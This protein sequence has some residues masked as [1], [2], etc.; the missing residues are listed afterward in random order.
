MSRRKTAVMRRPGLT[1]CGAVLCLWGCTALSAYRVSAQEAPNLQ[2]PNLRRSEPGAAGVLRSS[3]RGYPWVNLTDAAQLRTE[4]SEVMELS[5]GA[6]ESLDPLSLAAGDFDQDGVPDLVCGFGTSTGGILTLYRGNVDSVFPDTPEAQRRKAA[7]TFHDGPFLPRPYAVAVPEKPQLLGVGDFNADRYLDIVL[8]GP[9]GG[10]L[11]LL[12]GDGRGSF[13]P[14]QETRLPGQVT[15]LLTG[16]INRRDRLADI[17]LGVSGPEGPRL[18]VFEW[19]HGALRSDPEV[20]PL[21]SEA[22]ALALGQLDE[23]Y[24]ID[25]AVAAGSEVLIMHGRD[26]S[27]TVPTPQDISPRKIESYSFTSS[28][29]S[30]AVGDF[31]G[32]Y[33]PELAVLLE[34]STIELLSRSE[35]GLETRFRPVVA[36]MSLTPLQA[37]SGAAT[38]P[39]LIRA[40][41]S[42]LPKD[43]LLLVDT[44]DSS[45]HVLVLDD[46]KRA[47]AQSSSAPETPW[48]TALRV[49]DQPVAVL[50]MRLNKHALSGLVILRKGTSIPTTME[51]QPERTFTVNQDTDESDANTLDDRCDVDDDDGNGEQCTLRAAIDQANQSVGLDEIVFDEIVFEVAKISPQ[52]PLNPTFF[53]AVTI[54]GTLKEGN[55]V[56]LDG[57]AAGISADGL[58][59][60]GGDS[61]IRNLVIHS[62]QQTGV[63]LS[64]NNNRLEGSF[65]GTNRTGQEIRKN[66]ASGVR[67]GGASTKTIIGGATTASRNIIS[68]NGD[69]FVGGV[70]IE[71]PA[72]VENAILNNLIGVDV[73][74]TRP[75]ENANP[76]VRIEEGATNNVVAHNLI[77]GNVQDGILLDE[78]TGTIIQGNGIGI[79]VDDFPGLPNDASG[80][81]IF[82]STGTTVG[83][84][85]DRP[86]KF[87]FLA[88]MKSPDDPLTPVQPCNVIAGNKSQGNSAGIA[89]SDSSGTN[90]QGN[91]IMHNDGAGVSI[92]QF[93]D[94]S[95]LNTIGGITPGEGN[96]IQ[97][98]IL[99]GIRVS[100]DK[101]VT[102]AILGNS[103]FENGGLGINL[104]VDGVTEN[105]DDDSDPGPNHLQNFPVLTAVSA[106]TI[107]GTLSGAAGRTFRLEFFSN[108]E[109][110]PS[111]HGEGEKFIDSLE[112]GEQDTAQCTTTQDGDLTFE[113]SFGALPGQRITATATELLFDA[114]GNTSEFSKCFQ[115]R[116]FRVNSAG[117]E[118]DEDEKEGREFD[119]VCDTGEPEVNGK[120][121]C[122]LRAAVAEANAA[123]ITDR[124]EFA[125]KDLEIKPTHPLKITTPVIIDGTGQNITIDGSNRPSEEQPF[126]GLIIGGGKSLVKGL[127]IKGFKSGAGI[128]LA[129]RGG[130]KIRGNILTENNF[131]IGIGPGSDGNRIGG[132]LL[133]ESCLDPCN[134]VSGNEIS[135]I[136]ITSSKLNRVQGNFIGTDSTGTRPSGN[137]L[138]VLISSLED[139]PPAEKNMIGGTQPGEGNLIS[140]NARCGI[141]LVGEVDGAVIQGNFIGTSAYKRDNYLPPRPM[142][143]R[144]PTIHCAGQ[145]RDEADIKG[146]ESGW[147]SNWMPKLS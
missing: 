45:I 100:G 13:G 134:W 115:P 104:G 136:E 113:T 42:S 83:G 116:V 138:G 25:L 103:I 106:Q 33:E 46:A 99:D 32:T 66:G 41:I 108:T 129:Q 29:A 48:M 124:I 6:Q 16:E 8:A 114:R 133:E 11:F 23:D 123:S 43:D 75:L 146:G 54:D 143:T 111:G 64:G 57:S 126:D 120:P 117:D 62:F 71:G 140:G 82:D 74:G 95:S 132:V 81:R 49:G 15:A 142:L 63:S 80:I 137:D 68:G 50:P 61:L 24:P 135:G 144:H 121:E 51:P 20:F 127:T 77:S 147:F 91:R 17:V 30:L 26:R 18:L 21:P 1:Y 47:S 53:E 34:D 44:Q 19:S 101:T 73:T 90:V 92:S 86:C 119:G 93:A 94:G 128:V 9:G 67:I 28:I 84:P 139:G 78:A 130:N 40:R 131:G 60:G 79:D 2:E 107:T 70:V 37:P 5:L 12:P 125:I 102:N 122:T 39:R 36:A 35:E 58:S 59:I 87:Q 105:D 97:A 27:V 109:C 10:I 145:C 55:R 3:G 69:V 38:A 76:G 52:K 65:I 89:I 85:A 110:D 118:T 4:Y 112:C 56:E 14:A 72:A 22:T 31:A 141:N 98:N 88:E 7:G 96:I